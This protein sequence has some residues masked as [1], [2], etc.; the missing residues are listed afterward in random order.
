[1][2][3]EHLVPGITAGRDLPCTALLS[4]RCNMLSY[5]G[6]AQATLSA[7]QLLKL[8]PKQQP[9]VAQGRSLKP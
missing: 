6:A 1:M 5:A 4:P 7:L 3:G 8:H 2:A 9:L